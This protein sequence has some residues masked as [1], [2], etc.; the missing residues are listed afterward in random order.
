MLCCHNNVF[1]ICV[2]GVFYV[3]CMGLL[4][5]FLEF[6][7]KMI[8]GIYSGLFILSLYGNWVLMLRNFFSFGNN[9]YARG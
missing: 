3:K 4:V 1:F 7:H 5:Y 8:S 9:I 6:Y 2:M